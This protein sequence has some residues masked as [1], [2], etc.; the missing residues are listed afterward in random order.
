MYCI[1]KDEEVSVDMTL[2]SML[3][4]KVGNL[5]RVV[6]GERGQLDALEKDVDCQFA[7][8]RRSGASSVEEDLSSFFASSKKSSAAKTNTDSV[9]KGT[10]QSFFMKQSDKK[11][12]K[13]DGALIDEKTKS[14]SNETACI[15]LLDDED[16]DIGR[17]MSLTYEK[18]SQI[19]K[20]K[21]D[22]VSACIS[23][24]EEEDEECEKVTSSQAYTQNLV[25]QSVP[26]PDTVTNDTTFICH[27]CTFKNQTDMNKCIVCQTP[28][29]GLE[30]DSLST[31]WSCVIC[32]YSNMSNASSC[33][34]CGT[35][36]SFRYSFGKEHIN[37]TSTENTHDIQ[38]LAGGNDFDDDDEEWDESDLAAIDLATKSHLTHRHSSLSQSSDLSIDPGESREESELLSFAVSLNSGRIALYLAS[39][40]Q[41]LHVNFE[42]T[43]VLTKQSADELEELHYQRQIPNST[44][45]QA[46]AN[47]SFDDG[48]I[49]QVLSALD[50]DTLNISSNDRLQCICNEVKQFITC[51]LNLREVEKKV[52]KESG[53]AVTASSLI[54]LARR[55][56][57]S[58]I[59]G[60][61]ERY[62]G[63]AK[64][65]AIANIKNGCSTAEDMAVVNGQGCAWCA[66]PFLCGK[67]ATYCSQS[68]VEEGRVR[69]GGMFLSSKIRDQL[70][71]L[72]HGKC[73]KV[74]FLSRVLYL[75]FD[76]FLMHLAS[77]C[78]VDAHA[79]FC[80]LKSLHPAEVSNELDSC[81]TYLNDLLNHLSTSCSET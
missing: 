2:W 74:R 54:Q 75:V 50:T 13:S 3:S 66:K 72:E 12:Q 71:A 73:T 14:T 31:S 46:K 56:L 62:Q 11:V 51:Y 42:V 10:I 53:Q 70:F 37:T 35:I 81:L 17:P 55:L 45:T 7:T 4:S 68:C 63:G 57:V 32:T 19:H 15:S 61:T 16:D 49:R 30:P 43:Q 28:R 33:E 79:L 26:P 76:M 47:L 39:S 23:L 34:M 20:K 77:K 27:G 29:R 58:T 25:E 60:T 1:C 48:A 38:Y 24:L 59:T 40:G 18:K 41:P 67:G 6:D 44:T 36:R 8:P 64:E 22:T 52:V 65:R 78:N 9:V 69:R 5:G 80:K 21:H